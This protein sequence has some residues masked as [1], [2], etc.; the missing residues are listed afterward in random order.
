MININ[1]KEFLIECI[2]YAA[3][4]VICAVAQVPMWATVLIGLCMVGSEHLARK[5]EASKSS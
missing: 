1:I 5:H 2:P 4:G 3:A